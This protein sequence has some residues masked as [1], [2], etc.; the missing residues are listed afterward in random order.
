M[1]H[2]VVFLETAT[3]TFCFATTGV[4]DIWSIQL[5]SSSSAKEDEGTTSDINEEGSWY[6]P[7][8]GKWQANLSCYF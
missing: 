4:G 8:Q 6:Y 1:V 3:I 7:S 5:F 2:S